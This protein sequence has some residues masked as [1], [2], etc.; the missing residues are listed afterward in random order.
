MRRIV[1]S[2]REA[3][4]PHGSSQGVRIMAD[5]VPAAIRPL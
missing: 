2:E 5:I 3:A 1:V 4:T